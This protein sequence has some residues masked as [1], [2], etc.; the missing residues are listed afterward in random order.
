[1]SREQP[2][3]DEGTLTKVRPDTRQPRRYKVLL[4]NDDFTTMHFVVAVLVR[5]FHKSE[6]E[7]TRI[8]LE[9]HMKG[10]GVAG[11]YPR[12]QAETKVAQV[13]A[14]AEKEGFPLLVTMEPE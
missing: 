8:M 7:A 12:D 6:T 11:L 2:G 13:T 14:E 3:V 1:M 5:H 4:H 9:V 10:F